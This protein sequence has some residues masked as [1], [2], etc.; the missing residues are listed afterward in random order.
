MLLAVNLYYT[1]KYLPSKR[2]RKLRNKWNLATENIEIKELSDQQAPLA[3]L[4]KEH[5]WRHDDEKPVFRLFDEEIRLYN[6]KLY[7][8]IRFS[9]VSSGSCGWMPIEQL[10]YKLSGNKPCWNNEESFTVESIIKE[11]N[12]KKKKDNLLKRAETYFILDGKVW[13]ESG[14]PRYVITTFG[15]GHNHGGTGMFID[16]SYNPNIADTNYFNAL[17]RKKA[18]DY[19]NMVAKN[20]GDTNDVGKFE[21]GMNI[22]VHVPEAVKCNPKA[23]HG[24]GDPFINSIQNMVNESSC[25]IESAL[26][27]MATTIN[28]IS[29]I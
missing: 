7:K 16:Y 2:H 14:E 27:V 22:I 28:D 24:K 25:I 6:G 13:S 26:L 12:Y 4:V 23:E 15:L 3:F 11:S 19:A 21:N 18:F 10:Q 8:A 9:S 20:R 5:G 1:E 17:E 29:K